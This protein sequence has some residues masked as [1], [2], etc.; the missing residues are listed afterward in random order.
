MMVCSCRELSRLPPPFLSQYHL[1]II[2]T[3]IAQFFP[4]VLGT[5]SMADEKGNLSYPNPT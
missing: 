3:A 4:S 1:Q 5:T 2:R